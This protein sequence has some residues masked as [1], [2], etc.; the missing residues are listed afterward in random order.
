MEVFVFLA[1]DFKLVQQELVLIFQNSNTVKKRCEVVVCDALYAI[2]NVHCFGVGLQYLLWKCFL[3]LQDDL[4]CFFNSL[5]EDQL[6]LLNQVQLSLL[7]LLMLPPC[8]LEEV[9]LH[10]EVLHL[11]VDL[12]ETLKLTLELGLHFGHHTLQVGFAACFHHP[13]TVHLFRDSV[14]HLRHFPLDLLKIG[15]NIKLYCLDY[16]LLFEHWPRVKFMN[17]IAVSIDFYF[18]TL[19]LFF[20]LTFEVSQTSLHRRNLFLHFLLQLGLPVFVFYLCA[21]FVNLSLQVLELVLWLVLDAPKYFSIFFV[22]F[23]QVIL[24][25]T[26][27]IE[28]VFERAFF[29]KRA[30]RLCGKI[31]VPLVF[32]FSPHIKRDQ[33]F[34]FQ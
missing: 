16:G 33:N 13:K 9:V 8:L 26:L 27:F 25:Q 10:L 24:A 32:K 31:F 20:H 17:R 34:C 30:E 2:Y 12:G 11:S 14:L 6:V 22:Q 15:F 21:K 5:L 7:L 1:I 28:K 4:L 19:N 18:K 23:F 29:A 3:L